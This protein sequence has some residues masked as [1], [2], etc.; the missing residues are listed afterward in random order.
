[1]AKPVE[2]QIGSRKYLITKMDAFTALA[3]FGDL[4]KEILPA[5]GSLAGNGSDT[6]IA[7]IES[8]SSRLS[9]KQL[10]DWAD[11]L[12]TPDNVAYQGMDG[13]YHKLKAVDR[14]G[15]FDNAIE[16]IELIVE[17]VRVNFAAPLTQWLNRSG[18]ADKLKA[19]Q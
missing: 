13:E 9:G 14:E 4:Q 12:I 16:I 11:R 5:V 8:L 10:T 2:V 3:V 6:A 19:A 7:A 1:M 18:L 15:V 17:I